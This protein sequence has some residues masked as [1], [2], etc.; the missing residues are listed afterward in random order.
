MGFSLVVARGAP[1]LPSWVRG[2]LTAVA[3]LVVE[4]GLQA[5]GLR[6]AVPGLWSTGSVVVAHWLICS[7]A[8]GI[9]PHLLS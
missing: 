4:R 5:R 7:V 1:L 2:L 9:F 6:S 8:F 3:S